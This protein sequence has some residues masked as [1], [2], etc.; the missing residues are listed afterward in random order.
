[1]VFSV[2][3]NINKLA[4]KWKA[5]D[6]IAIFCAR[7][8]LYLM[9]VFLLLAALFS[10]NWQMFLYPLS[11]GLFAAFVIDKIIYF[12]YKERR[13]AELINTKILIPVPQN[14][15]FPSRHASLLFGLSFCLFFYS[16]PLAIIFIICSCLVGIARVFCGVHWFHD[17]LGGFTAGFLSAII[18]YYLLNLIIK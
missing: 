17:I 5:L 7:Y 1:M 10:R 6:V 12:F 13:P 18:T 4:G 2:F 15:S 8:L 16:I 9:I 14:P 11:S 3:K